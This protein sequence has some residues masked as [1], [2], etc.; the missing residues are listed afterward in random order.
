MWSFCFTNQLS[1]SAYN[2]YQRYVKTPN[3]HLQYINIVGK[4]FPYTFP[5]SLWSKYCIDMHQRKIYSRI[6]NTF[7]F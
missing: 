3:L 4:D 5:Y 1:F 2:M 6:P 7:L